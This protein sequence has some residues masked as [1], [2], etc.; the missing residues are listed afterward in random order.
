MGIIFQSWRNAIITNHVPVLHPVRDLE[1]LTR[2]VHRR[3]RGI[4]IHFPNQHPP[5]LPG[6]MLGGPSLGKEGLD[7]PLGL[8]SEV[9]GLDASQLPSGPLA[10]RLLPH[11]SSPNAHLPSPPF[12]QLP[13]AS[14]CCLPRC[15]SDPAPSSTAIQSSARKP[16]KLD[17]AEESCGCVIPCWLLSTLT[18]SQTQYWLQTGALPNHRHSQNDTGAPG[19][20]GDAHSP[21]ASVQHTGAGLRPASMTPWNKRA[22]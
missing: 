22:L 15:S 13:L 12:A 20:P 5:Q 10:P 14:G 6:A 19:H 8:S 16:A 1:E 18:H 9:Q 11:H 2:E 17:G 7:A 3:F 21:A 4:T